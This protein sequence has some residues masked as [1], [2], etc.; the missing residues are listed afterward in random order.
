MGGG[1]HIG[2]GGGRIGGGFSGRVGHGDVGG[3]MTSRGF[4][5]GGMSE[6]RGSHISRDADR[7]RFSSRDDRGRFA[8]RHDDGDRHHRHHHGHDNFFIGAYPYVYDYDYYAGNDCEWLR[9]RAIATGSE[10]WWSRYQSCIY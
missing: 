9:Q 1:G 7:G 3:R 2:G 4:A 8:S 6:R 10:Y 5:N